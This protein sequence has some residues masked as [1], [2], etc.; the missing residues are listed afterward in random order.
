MGMKR[1]IV[2][3]VVIL[4]AAGV[5]LLVK[6]NNQTP[7][8]TSPNQ[9][10]NQSTSSTNNQN[11]QQQSAQPVATDKV[12]MQNIAFTPAN[13]TVK[14]GATVT[15]TNQDAVEHT[16]TENDGKNGPSAPPLSQGQS[17]TFTFNEVGT[18]HYHCTIHSEMTGTVTVTAS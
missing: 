18:F 11:T 2:I 13:I 15:W 7:S 16:V 3:A 14:K 17:Y 12:T 4:V 10:T 6:G 1:I 8:Q 5:W 9:N